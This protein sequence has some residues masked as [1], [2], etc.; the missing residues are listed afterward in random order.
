MNIYFSRPSQSSN[1]SLSKLELN[2][3]VLITYL[4]ILYPFLSSYILIGESFT[5]G[6]V[7]LLAITFLGITVFFKRK[8]YISSFFLPLFV[9]ILLHTL[10]FSFIQI[11][12][13]Q[14]DY[15]VLLRTLRYFLYIFII[16]F[17]SQSVFLFN[18]GY[19]FY[20]KIG[21]LT[22]TYLFLQYIILIFFNF[23]LPGHL[24]IL[25]LNRPELYEI[26]TLIFQTGDYFRPRSFFDEPSEFAVFLLPLLSLLM[27]NNKMKDFKTSL[28]L[29][30]SI[31]IST[32]FIGFF[33]VIFFWVIYFIINIDNTKILKLIPVFLL[34][35]IVGFF[36]FQNQFIGLLNRL[37]SGQIYQSDRLDFIFNIPSSLNIFYFYNLFGSGMFRIPDGIFIPG[38]TRFYLYFGQLGLFFLALGLFLSIYKHK[39]SSRITIFTFLILSFFDVLLFGKLFIIIFLF[40]FG[41]ENKLNINKNL[42]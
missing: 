12:S 10:F 14:F 40:S 13:S 34:V 24:N 1:I 11:Y 32:S 39:I 22:A 17:Y 7:L 23:Y 26:Q 19:N 31:I 33:I 2:I 29:S 25:T 37:F 3:R 15:T 9:Y 30:L 36:L 4:T 20:K 6:D 41:S 18:K 16:V 42:V 35:I 27:F 38:F 21:I 5:L 28:Y 8:I